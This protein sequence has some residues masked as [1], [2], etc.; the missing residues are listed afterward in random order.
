MINNKIFNEYYIKEPIK[1]ERDEILACKNH[2]AICP[3]CNGSMELIEYH[4]VV[5]EWLTFDEYLL[6]AIEEYTFKY[7]CIKCSVNI[8]LNKTIV[9]QYGI[10]D[11]N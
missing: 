8:E 2:K 4:D 10:K 3:A 5:T 6:P 1:T 7:Q 11:V 9:L